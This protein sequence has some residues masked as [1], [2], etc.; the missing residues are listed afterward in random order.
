MNTIDAASSVQG[1]EAAVADA[2]RPLPTPSREGH[3]S[4]MGIL[5]RF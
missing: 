1:T 2:H 4:S 5:G 3:F